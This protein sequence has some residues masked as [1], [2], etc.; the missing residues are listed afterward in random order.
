MRVAWAF[1]RLV[2]AD[3]SILG[4]L[5]LFVPLFARTR[6]F[7]ESVE[8]ALP[9]LFMW[10]C[11]FVANDLDDKE[12]DEVNHPDRPLPQGQ[13]SPTFAAST[14]FVS[15]ALALLTVKEYVQSDHVV[16]YYSVLV[17]FISY[18]YVVE[19]L[20]A[21]KPAYVAAAIAA[22]IAILA[23]FYPS[24]PR[25]LLVGQAA[26]CFA[27]GRELCMD[28][29]DR[30]GDNRSILTNLPAQGV[31]G[32]AFGIQALGSAQ[33]VNVARSSFDWFILVLLLISTA[34]AV[35][36]WFNLRNQRAAIRVMKAQLVLGLFL[37]L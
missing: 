6:D 12:R 21:L 9:L 1:L 5:T 32:V 37:L 7:W 20:P 16:W 28:L 34:A 4:F 25:F 22:P 19:Y 11:A 17:C 31:A 3:S 36:C 10:I 14:Y 29:L 30:R 33:L 15:L 26:F 23:R 24:E 2:R 27:L 8:R 35:L 18:H 13:L